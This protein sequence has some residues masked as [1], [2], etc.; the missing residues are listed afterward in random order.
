MPTAEYPTG[1]TE[2]ENKRID[3]YVLA[4]NEWWSAHY[5]KKAK[6]LEDMGMHITAY[7]DALN[8]S[9]AIPEAIQAI[10]DHFI[11]KE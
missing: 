3:S 9:P 6:A 2:A 1:E 5:N 4:T 7:L 8:G 10:V 11:P